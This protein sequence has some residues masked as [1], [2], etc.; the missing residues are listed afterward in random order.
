MQY[1]LD[2]AGYSELD[3]CIVL[4][5]C[6]NSIGNAESYN[7]TNVNSDHLALRIQMKQELNA[8][9]KAEHGEELR[10][11]KSEEEQQTR[12]YNDIIRD[13]IRKGN[14]ADMESFMRTLARAAENKLSLKPPKLRKRGCYPEL[15]NSSM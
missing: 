13:S 6:A 9:A 3:L 11:A 1:F 7:L 8:L 12:E 15:T 2:T 10:G 4:R 5:K 14:A